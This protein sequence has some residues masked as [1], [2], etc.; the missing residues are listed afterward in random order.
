MSKMDILTSSIG[1]M[2]DL[3][4]CYQI[5]NGMKIPVKKMTYEEAMSIE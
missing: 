2:K 3:I 4:A 5:D 1:Q